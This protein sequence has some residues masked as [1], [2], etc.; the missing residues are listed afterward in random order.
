MKQLFVDVVG[1][2]GVASVV[3]GVNCIHQPAAFI[4]AGVAMSAWA[5]VVSRR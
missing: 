2:V 1:L 4:V 3:W 5:F